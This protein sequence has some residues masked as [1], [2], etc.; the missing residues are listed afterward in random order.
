[1]YKSAAVVLGDV[2]AY[3]HAGGQYEW[4]SAAPVVVARAA[5]LH[6]SRLDGSPLKYN[7]PN[8]Y[9][10]DLLVCRPELAT[11]APV[12]LPTSY[13][14]NDHDDTRLSPHPARGTGS[15]G[16]PHHPR[17]RRRVGEAGAA[18]LRRQGFHHDA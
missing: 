3:V 10:P 17:G 14:V 18:V 11:P 7:Q 2:D 15:R 4:D 1:G 12:S 13:E 9:L 16:D 6:T 8:P 5:G